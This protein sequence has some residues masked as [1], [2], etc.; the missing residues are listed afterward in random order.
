MFR[1]CPL[2][3]KPVP[4]GIKDCYQAEIGA[5]LHAIEAAPRTALGKEYDT[6]DARKEAE[7]TYQSLEKA[8]NSVSNINGAKKVWKKAQTGDFSEEASDA[9]LKKLHERVK[10]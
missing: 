5:R 6:E 7:A 4:D 2:S 1:H 8:V 9:L 10:A 3:G